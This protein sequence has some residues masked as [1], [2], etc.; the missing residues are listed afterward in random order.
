MDDGIVVSC[1][2]AIELVEGELQG[3]H[4][5][6]GG[7]GLGKGES[8]YMQPDGFDVVAVDTVLVGAEVGLSL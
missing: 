2:V 7:D 4:L 5:S 1:A 8:I 6:Q 3:I